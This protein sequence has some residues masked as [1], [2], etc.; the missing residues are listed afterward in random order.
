MRKTIDN[1]NDEIK[2]V[3]LF[4]IAQFI[5]VMDVLSEYEKIEDIKEDIKNRRKIYSEYIN[6]MSKS[7]NFL[8]LNLYDEYIETKIEKCREIYLATEK[9]KK[10]S[11]KLEKKYNSF[12]K[13]LN[14]KKQNELD[15]IKRLIY[16]T[17]KFDMHLSYKIGV[18]DGIRIKNSSIKNY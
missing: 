2:N 12:K 18:V 4:T 15:E 8:A 16:E 7:D 17:C 1:V 9:Y 11:K 6:Q 14:E 10:V 13:V 3:E 5:D